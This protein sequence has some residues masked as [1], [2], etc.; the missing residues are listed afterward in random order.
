LEDHEKIHLGSITLEVIYCPGHSPGSVC[1]YNAKE[2]ILWGGDALFRESI[3]R[4]DLPGGDYETLEHNIQDRLFTLPDET[5]V[6]PGHG[7]PTTI[8][9][10]KVNN[11]F[12]G[13]ARLSI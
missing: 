3:G 7:L 1:F 10:E 12:V 2:K 4:T 5:E 6:Y 8:G 13:K 11:P 9:Y